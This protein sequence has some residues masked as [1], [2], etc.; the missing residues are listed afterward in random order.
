MLRIEILEGH[1]QPFSK[2]VNGRNGSETRWY[3]NAY[4]HVGQ[5]FPVQFRFGLNSEQNH[6]MPGKYTIDPSSYR[7]GKYGD[8]EINP[9]EVRFMRLN[10]DWSTPVS[11]KLE[12]PQ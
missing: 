4:A 5:A 11:R 8:L 6:Y 1:H 10:E 2:Q 9:F 7:V 3:Q 12:K